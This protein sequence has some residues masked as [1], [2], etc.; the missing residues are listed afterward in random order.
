[1]SRNK[2]YNGAAIYG[3]FNVM[4]NKIYIGASGRVHNRFIQHRARFRAGN[5]SIPMY[6]E[7]L[8]NFVF[9]ILHKLSDEDYVKFGKV[10]EILYVYQAKD[11]KIDVYNQ[12]LTTP[13]YD[14][15]TGLVCALLGLE[16]KMRYSILRGTGKKH[17]WIRTMKKSSR[18]ELLDIINNSIDSTREV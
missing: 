16:G 11:L 7:P 2:K 17:H 5:S 8:E 4:E 14:N 15:P 1:M 13:M 18:R 9:M 6:N 10:L 12:Q 3:L